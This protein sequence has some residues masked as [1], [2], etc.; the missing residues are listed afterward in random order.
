M[1]I[2]KLLYVYLYFFSFS[3]LIINIIICINIFFPLRVLKNEFLMIKKI[4]C[5]SYRDNM[6]KNKEEKKLST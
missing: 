4:A 6:E 1:I 5:S 2:L 3:I